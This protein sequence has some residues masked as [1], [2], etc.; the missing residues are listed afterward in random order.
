MERN[1]GPKALDKS[2]IVSILLCVHMYTI[3]INM[4]YTVLLSWDVYMQNSK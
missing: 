3:I 4:I 1:P 2:I